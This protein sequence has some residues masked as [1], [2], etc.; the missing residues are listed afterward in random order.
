MLKHGARHAVIDP[1]A[2]T[3]RP[4][5]AGLSAA[6]HQ[7]R[8]GSS[9]R[10]HPSTLA[11]GCHQ[12]RLVDHD[13]FTLDVDE[14]GRGSQVDPNFLGEHPVSIPHDPG[15]VRVHVARVAHA[16][17]LCTHALEFGHDVLVTAIQVI[18]VVEPGRARRAECRD[19]QRRP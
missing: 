12:G 3:H 8:R 15:K 18:D 9:D 17:D 10:Q 6:A 5:R 4:D 2:V 14:D 7:L 11:I 16:R 1:V 13:T 19:H